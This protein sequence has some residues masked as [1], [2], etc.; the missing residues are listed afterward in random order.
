[1][2]YATQNAQDA[3]IAQKLHVR[4][5]FV[6][7]RR[8]EEPMFLRILSALSL[9]RLRSAVSAGYGFRTGGPSLTLGMTVLMLGMTGLTLG[10]TQSGFRIRRENSGEV[11]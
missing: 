6:S 2:H 4:D 1:M 5:E 7:S 9:L 3:Q 11:A 10:A 8:F